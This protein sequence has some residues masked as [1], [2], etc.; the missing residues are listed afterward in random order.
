VHKD[1]ETLIAVQADD[2]GIRDIEARI[3]DVDR[4]EAELDARRAAATDAVARQRAS[5]EREEAKRAALAA[6][7]DEHRQLHQR[8][9]SQ[10]DQVRRMREATAA[11]AQVDMAQRILGDEERELQT[12]ARRVAD[13]R[14]GLEA[15]EAEL[16]DLDASQHEDRAT[17][18]AER[19]DLRAQLDAARRTRDGRAAA[20]PRSLLSRYERIRD[21][22]HGEALFKLR[23]LA[24]GSC[25]TAIPLQRRNQMV[26][27]AVVEV[28]EGCGVLLYAAAE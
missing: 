17:L 1:L 11:Q 9:V 26:D 27:G 23:G 3:A 25:D 14:Q 2:A 28:C 5:V 18:A 19:D 13:G 15:H 21:R 24:C 20:V 22:R 8:N 16:A 7:V 6:R 4:R 12:L 10:L